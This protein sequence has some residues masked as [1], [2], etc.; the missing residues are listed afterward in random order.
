VAPPPT[1][2]W[3]HLD[4]WAVRRIRV[5]SRRRPPSF[6]A[7]SSH[8]KVPVSIQTTP[9][10]LRR[11]SPLRA[12]SGTAIA[13]SKTCLLPLTR[14]PLSSFPSP[15]EIR[16]SA[17]KKLLCAAHACALRQSYC[18]LFGTQ[19]NC[20]VEDHIHCRH[21]T[22]PTARFSPAYRLFRTQHE[23]RKGTQCE[24][25]GPAW[26]PSTGLE[27]ARILA[28]S[29]LGVAFGFVLGHVL[30]NLDRL[31]SFALGSGGVTVG[32]ALDGP[33]G[34]IRGHA[35]APTRTLR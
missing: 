6:N 14:G 35:A 20:R 17:C 31:V 23:R 28:Q 26:A 32:T 33:A 5:F 7:P 9:S 2:Q 27:K 10:G 4:Y 8:S 13:A 21:V 34:M 19:K 24:A 30:L 12:L 3:W 16:E 15:Q 25:C 29:S 1:T 11:L 22:R 18:N